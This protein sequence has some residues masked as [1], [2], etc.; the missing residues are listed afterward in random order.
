MQN[1]D[2]KTLTLIARALSNERKSTILLL[3]LTESLSTEQIYERTNYP[4]SNIS[5][6]LKAFEHA[7]LVDSYR[8][9]YFVYYRAT[10]K[11]RTLVQAMG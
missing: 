1:P 9:S 7:G 2:T 8:E 5:N 10:K 4:A 11:A 3:L 6:Y